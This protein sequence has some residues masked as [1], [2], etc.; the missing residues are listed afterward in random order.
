MADKP[1]PGVTVAPG[2]RGASRG[3]ERVNRTPLPHGAL[4]AGH[5]RRFHGKHHSLSLAGAANN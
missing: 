4:P 5:G 2:L 1:H 3:P